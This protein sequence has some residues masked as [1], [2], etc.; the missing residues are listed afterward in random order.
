MQHNL[1]IP[2]MKSLVLTLLL[3]PFD[4]LDLKDLLVLGFLRWSHSPSTL[5]CPFHMAQVLANSLK[6]YFFLCF[7]FTFIPM[8][9][10][11]G[12]VREKTAWSYECV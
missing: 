2:S 9:S 8:V 12:G 11:Q 5:N 6:I 4:L 10:E 7:S 1:E 3:R